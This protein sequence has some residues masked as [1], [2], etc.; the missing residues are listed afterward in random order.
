[1]E[2]FRYLSGV[3]T[4]T[5]NPAACVGCGAC[6]EVCPQGALALAD[7]RARI[8]DRD[9]CMECGACVLN[10]PA[11]ALSVRPGVGCASYIL[12]NWLRRAG[13]RRLADRS[14]CCS[15]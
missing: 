15:D 12:G 2:A 14:A 10:C 8:V 1:M 11:D 5:L 3:S 4:L 13:F 9:G 7:G 6:C